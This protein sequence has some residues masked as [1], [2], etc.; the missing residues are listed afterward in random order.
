MLLPFVSFACL[1]SI[2]DGSW[3]ARW[4]WSQLADSKVNLP[5]C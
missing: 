1:Q 4:H 5:N 2:A 3:T